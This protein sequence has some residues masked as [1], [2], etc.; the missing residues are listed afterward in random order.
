MSIT[1]KSIMQALQKVRG[2]PVLTSN[3]CAD[4][5]EELRAVLAQEAGKVGS[6][7]QSELISLDVIG[8][9]PS[10]DDA[11]AHDEW[12]DN[13]AYAAIWLL[14]NLDRIRIALDLRPSPSVELDLVHS[15]MTDGLHIR[16]WENLGGLREGIH[17][18]YTSP[19][20]PVS[21]VLPIDI[22]QRLN[23]VWL[24]LDG[25]TELNGCVWGEKPEGRHQFWWRKELRSVVEDLNACLDKVKEL[26]Q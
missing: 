9:Y 15:K 23:D 5:A 26:N 14:Y 20:A 8:D 17:Q 12:L 2:A 11:D 10:A 19:P 22:K 3:Q 25:Q 4:L 18:L 13:N 1:M 6:S 21:V 7:L 16:R 24:F